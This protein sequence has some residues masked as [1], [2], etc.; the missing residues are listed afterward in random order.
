M[1]KLFLLTI[2]VM[3]LFVAGA[4]IAG[5]PDGVVGPWADEVVSFSQGLRANNTPVL[6][7][8]SNPNQALGTAEGTDTVNFVSLGFGGELVLKFD[9]CILNG[10]GNDIEIV[11]TSYGS[12]TCSSYPETVR[13]YASQDNSSWVDLGTSCLDG[14]CDLGSLSWAK[15]VKL[16]DESDSSKFSGTADG[17]D[18]DGVRAL[19]SF[20]T[21][22]AEP[23]TCPGNMVQ[24]HLETV[25]VPSNGSTVYSANVLKS[26]V[27]YILEASGT[28]TY[29]PAQ[30]PD[31]GIADAKYSLRP[32]GSYNPG[33]G[34][35]WISGDDLPLPW[36]NYL[37]VLVDSGPV[38]WGTLNPDH[39]YYL[40]L[41]GTGS[42]AGF[43]ILDSYYGDNSGSLQVDIY[44]CV[45][46]GDIEIINESNAIV[47]NNV[48]V[49]ANT[50]GNN[51]N[52][53]SGG[54][55]GDIDDT[56]AW[57]GGYAKSGNGGAGGDGGS[58]GT[59]WTGN[60]YA[61]TK[62]LNRIN[63]VITKIWR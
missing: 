49:I 23:L 62:I 11:E 24:K 29:W 31:A 6:A 4:V 39:I 54:R 50:G 22:P 1:K 42:T 9:N 37:E 48:T 33:P 40:L 12:P 15:Y 19:H 46:P 17:F 30:L 18:I 26:G 56:K 57:K 60:V 13:I 51:A 35:R 32:Q 44:K 59:I 36:T 61:K 14:A 27:K 10:E 43:R 52:G 41:D 16:V 2:P 34:P 28:Y 55:G 38:S 25:T 7:E 20:E 47:E 58:G 3:L 45:C 21:C 53:G 5:T 63:T 8:R